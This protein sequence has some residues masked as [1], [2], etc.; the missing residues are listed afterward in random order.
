MLMRRADCSRSACGSET[1]RACAN[2]VA[3]ERARTTS[4]TL[5]FSE[6]KRSSSSSIRFFDSTSTAPRNPARHTRSNAKRRR[7]GPRTGEDFNL[8]P[9]LRGL[10]FRERQATRLLAGCAPVTVEAVSTSERLA[11]ARL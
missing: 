9:Q 11:R 6:R 7:H 2:V 4:G 1:L 3:R 8:A 10:L 5:S